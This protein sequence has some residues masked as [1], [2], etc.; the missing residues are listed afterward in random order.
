MSDNNEQAQTMHDE[1]LA[2][3]QDV[4]NLMTNL[5]ALD[6]RLMDSL[7]KWQTW[8]NNQPDDPPVTPPVTNPSG[9]AMP[10]GDLPGWK[11]VFADDF[12][13]DVALGQFAIAN[14]D[15]WAA[16][17]NSW[18]DT[19]KHG[20]YEPKILSVHDN[21]LDYYIHTEGGKHLVA[22]PCPILPGSHTLSNGM[23]S[24][25]TYGRY[26]ICCRAD[27]LPGYK[28]V[29]LLWPDSGKG[30]GIGSPP[31]EGEIN[32][33]EGNLDGASSYSGFMHR[34]DS[35]NTSDQDWVGSSAKP[36]DWHVFTLEWA[37]NSCKFILN[38]QV[39]KEITSRVPNTS[40]RW[41][42]QAETNLDGTQPT[43]DATQGHI[44]I[45]WVAIWSK[46]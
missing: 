22:N 28:F 25:Q 46:A 36:G 17:P 18:Q 38:G 13:T 43:A 31:W 6:G 42:L 4:L 45:D 12:T 14:K 2:I 3:R 44:L 24:G 37:P 35:A 11:Q 29:P 27:A 5:D 34:K 30:T 41:A 32:W 16:Y 19:S 1:I 8:R 40:F 39:L 26:S 20:W 23:P 15:K 9:Q 21:V 10:V 33:P 7:N